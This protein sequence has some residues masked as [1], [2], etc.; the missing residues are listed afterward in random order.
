MG[1]PSGPGDSSV[2][3]AFHHV[4]A[5]QGA[6]IVAIVAV[7]VVGWNQLRSMQYRRAVARGEQFPAPSGNVA[8]EPS[9]RRFL[10]ITFGLLW[11]L[12]GLLQLQPGM[13]GG[14]PTAVI[15]PA[16]ATSPDPRLA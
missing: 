7:L 1:G 2:I 3:A 4:L 13:P 11:L 9:A 16:A 10:R 15:K 5:T 6:V 12:D 14:L 8:L